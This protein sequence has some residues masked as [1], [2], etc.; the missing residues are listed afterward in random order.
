MDKQLWLHQLA[1]EEITRC[2]ELYSTLEQRLS[3]LPKGSLLDRN[4][5]IY[6]AFRE[7]ERQY[8]KP[9]NED[10]QLLQNLKLRQYIKKALPF[11]KKKI[12]AYRQLLET[13]CIYDPVNIESAMGI[14]YQGI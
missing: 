3:E 9:I 13:D 7:N 4:G 12:R 6:R 1:I 5:H 14:I 2:E 10:R 8:Q 11:L